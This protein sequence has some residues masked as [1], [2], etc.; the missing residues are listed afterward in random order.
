MLYELTVGGLI[1][2]VFGVTLEKSKVME[3]SAIIGQFLFKKFIMLKV[4]VVAMVVSM[5]I[6]NAMNHAGL[7]VFKMK[8]FNLFSNILG[9]SLLG[10]G[11]ALS[12]TCP[13]TV[14]AQMGVGYKDAFFTFAG[15]LT[16]AYIYLFWGND[17]VNYL[18]PWTSGKI[19]LSDAMGVSASLLTGGIVLVLVTFLVVLEKW[20]VWKDDVDTLV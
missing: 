8:D 14:F 6:L 18:S 20:H 12:G 19:Q 3:A 2:L 13:G 1:G 15:G 17:I 7:F 10:A 4:F 5:I 11:I 16:A 9:G